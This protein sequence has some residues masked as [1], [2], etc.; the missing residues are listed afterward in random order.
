[1]EISQALLGMLLV[2]VYAVLWIVGPI[3]LVSWFR[4]RREE[5]TKRQI[6]VTDAIHGELGPIVSPEVKNP[7]WGPWQIRMAVPFT[8]PAAVGRILAV[9][10]EMV[11][12]SSEMQPGQYQVVLTPTEESPM[13]KRQR[14][15]GH[16]VRHWSRGP[17]VA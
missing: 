5:T 4:N 11:S 12:A 15:A 1:M 7:L 10:D 2:A 9:V 8:Q 17:V 16:P 13:G 14:G 3:L 6:A